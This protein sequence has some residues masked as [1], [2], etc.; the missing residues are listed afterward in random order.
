MGKGMEGLLRMREQF[1]AENEGIVIA[2][3]V[4]WLASPHT[5]R[6]KRQNGEIS[7]SSVVFVVTGSR[8]EKS[9]INRRIEAT[10]VWYSFDTYT[11][12]GPNS[13]C[14]R[15]CRW[16]HIEYKCGSKPSCGYRSGHHRTSNHKW[17]VLGR[18]ASPGL[19]CGHALVKSP[20]CI[21]NHI[22]FTGRCMNK[23]EATEA[24]R[25]S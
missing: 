23:M 4:R 15:S 16:G 21:E 25:Q 7:M 3:Q 18:N 20:N 22:A 24:A 6:E 19:Q 2:T 10:G 14:E 1:E 9:L 8:V 11:N 13:R 12:E 17:N 5:I